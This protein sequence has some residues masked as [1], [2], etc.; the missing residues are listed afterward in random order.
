MGL[1]LGVVVFNA[2]LTG[3]GYC[4]LYAA[5]RGR[6]GRVYASYGGVALLL[7]TGLVGV[8][9]CMLAP[10]GLRLG[11]GAFGGAAGALALAGLALGRLWEPLRRRLDAAPRSAD[12][13]RLLGD[14]VT[15]VAGFGIGLVALHSS[16]TLCRRARQLSC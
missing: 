7:G 16:R 11:L 5:L 15:T 8:V 10:L 4:L 2:V 12:A 3:V 6:S 1:I 14:V 9:L 13:P